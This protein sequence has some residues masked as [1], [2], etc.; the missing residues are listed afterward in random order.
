[1]ESPGPLSPP[2]TQ[3]AGSWTLSPRREA[4]TVLLGNQ[5]KRKSH[6]KRS[7]PP[8]SPDTDQPCPQLSNPLLLLS[9]QSGF[10]ETRGKPLARKTETKSNVQKTNYSRRRNFFKK[11]INSKKIHSC[12]QSARTEPSEKKT[13]NRCS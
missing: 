9:R 12:F 11:S 2:S 10:S 4:E 5:L 1:M 8:R 3:N 13:P 7:K 6:H